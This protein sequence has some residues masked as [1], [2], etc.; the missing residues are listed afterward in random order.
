MIFTS[1]IITY[2]LIIIDP[3]AV[4]KRYVRECGTRLGSNAFPYALRKLKGERRAFCNVSRT[5]RSNLRI[6][7]GEL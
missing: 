3:F 4:V 1:N 6:K 5:R 2:L 7:A